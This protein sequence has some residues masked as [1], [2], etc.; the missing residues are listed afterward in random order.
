[1]IFRVMT[2]EDI[3]ELIKNDETRYIE[4]KKSTGELK[5]A[6]HS[7]CAMLNSGGG[8]VIIGI[9]PSSLKITGQKVTDKTRQEIAIEIRK[10]EPFVNMAV[11]YID[12]PDT[13]G[14]QLIVINADKS[15]FRDAPYVFDGKPYYKLESTTMLMPQFMYEEKLRERD[16]DKFR[17]DSQVADEYGIAD[18]DEKRIREVVY[19]GVRNGR[20]NASA[21]D[22]PIESLLGKL[23]LLKNGKPTNAAAILFAK[24]L[25]YLPQM[26]LRMA[27]FKGVDKN[28]FIDNKCETGNF[29]DLLDAGVSFCFRNLKISGEIVG[30]H[31]NEKL[32]IPI[33]ALRE[34]IINALCHRQYEHTNGSVSLGIYDDRI[35]IVN[36]GKF[37]PQISAENIKLP[38][39]SYPYN[40][41]IA[42]VLY[43]TTFL[44]RWG[45]G[46]GRMIDSCKKQNVP[47]P[48]WAAANGTVSIIFRRSQQLTSY[49]NGS[50]TNLT[51]QVKKLII[52]IGNQ[53]LTRK[54]VM[55]QV[56]LASSSNIMES[57]LKPAIEQGYV[58]MLYPDK[59]RHPQQKYMLTEKGLSVLNII[60][61][62]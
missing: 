38:H 58:T 35:E 8:V 22:D 60:T 52:S 46:V 33:E 1:M 21:N 3:K 30:L 56:K 51:S 7:V 49:S 16:A 19:L 47:E 40:K 25:Q 18:L 50:I 54:Q 20:I 45:S 44:E 12:V 53:S 34:A 11:D 31:R 42:Q 59:P 48:E 32:E 27:C 10:L 36:P 28:V 15:I 26:E 14:N 57:Y 6:M 41:S 62:K 4:L 29:F 43:L 24:D 37:P 17:W 9:T 13:D 2:I 61:N 39:E 23:K 5:D 55:L